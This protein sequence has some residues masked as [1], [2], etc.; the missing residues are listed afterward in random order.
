MD[1]VYSRRD[2]LQLLDHSVVDSSMSLFHDSSL[3]CDN[4]MHS[5]ASARA[6]TAD[7]RVLCD[8]SDLLSRNDGSPSALCLPKNMTAYT[9]TQ[10]DIDSQSSVATPGSQQSQLHNAVGALHRSSVDDF[11]SQLNMLLVPLS[12]FITQHLAM[13]QTWLSCTSYRQ[14]VASICRHIA[15]VDC[16]D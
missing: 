13:L 5:V 1:S 7:Q 6:A 11:V 4:P 12:D 10:P 8:T 15:E 9:S 2:L 3:C 16:V 14:L